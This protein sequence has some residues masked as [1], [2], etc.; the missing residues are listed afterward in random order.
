MGWQFLS[1]VNS[2]P[3]A[4]VE[5]PEEEQELQ[6]VEQSVHVLSAAR[7]YLEPHGVAQV[8]SSKSSKPLAQFEHPAEEHLS[9][10]AEQSTQF[11][12]VSMYCFEVHGAAQVRSTCNK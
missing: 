8:L 5:H 7:Y 6:F 4:H 3:V 1:E 10:F 9:Q 2:K 11:A 12:S